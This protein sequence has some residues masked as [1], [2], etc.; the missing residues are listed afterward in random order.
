MS[1]F[2]KGFI[3]AIILVYVV[4]PLDAMPGPMDDI[5]VLALSIMANTMTNKNPRVAEK[6]VVQM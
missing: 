1:G 4:F 2:I 3:F 5:I 6:E